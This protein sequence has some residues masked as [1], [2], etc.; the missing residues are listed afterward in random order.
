MQQH[1]A[2]MSWWPC[3]TKRLLI[4]ALSRTTANDRSL[5]HV[6]QMRCKI[7]WKQGRVDLQ[8]EMQHRR[9]NQRWIGLRPTRCH[10]T[11]QNHGD[12]V[13]AEALRTDWLPR[14][15]RERRDELGFFTCPVHGWQV[16]YSEAGGGPTV[17]Q[18]AGQPAPMQQTIGHERTLWQKW[19][20]TTLLSRV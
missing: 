13:D 1:A 17:E 14:C 19:P 3:L 4:T 6:S 11:L 12:A 16:N 8:G 18:R 15:E 7:R 2:Q 9:I 20:R 5:N 10:I